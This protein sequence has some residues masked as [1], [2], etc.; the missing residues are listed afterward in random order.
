MASD[1]R[2]RRLIS[3]RLAVTVKK[4]NNTNRAI[5]IGNNVQG[6]ISNCKTVITATM[7]ASDSGKNTFH[8]S[9]MS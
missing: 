9:S 5:E 7:F 1:A 3:I 2:R 4:P 6:L 8:V